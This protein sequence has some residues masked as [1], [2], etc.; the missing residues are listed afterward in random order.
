MSPTKLPSGLCIFN[1]TPHPLYF[2]CE[3]GR[4]VTAESDGVINAIPSTKTVK[5]TRQ[6]TLNTVAFHESVSGRELID[7]WKEIAPKALIVGSI[8]AAQAFPGE[9]VA[10]VPAQSGRGKHERSKRTVRAD[11]FTTFKESGNNGS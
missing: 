4:V 5:E 10:P 9:V 11:R 7:K 8:V 6:Y 2:L 1:A 3:D